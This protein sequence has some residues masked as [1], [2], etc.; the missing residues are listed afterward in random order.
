[1]N[2]IE[3][4]FC[5][6]CGFQLKIQKVLSE[7]IDANAIV[8]CE[9]YRYPII[10]GILILKK[11]STV[12]NA[13]RLMERN[14]LS[15]ALI[16]LIE[17]GPQGGDVIDHISLSLDQASHEMLG[18]TTPFH[19]LWL[20]YKKMTSRPLLEKTTKLTFFAAIDSLKWKSWGNYL[21][22]RF[23]SPDF[24]AALP[25][26]HLI[27]QTHSTILDIGCGAGHSS[28]IIAKHIPE[29]RIICADKTFINLY[30]AKK[31]FVK[32]ASFIC[33]DANNPLP[34][35]NESFSS[36]F[37][38]DAFHYVISKRLLAK[39][40]KRTL[41]PDGIL[42]LPHLHNSLTNI[43][44]GMAVEAL[45]PKRYVD[46]FDNLEVRLIPEDKV[47]E[48]F[49]ANDKIDLKEKTSEQELKNSHAIVLVASDNQR[50]FRVYQNID[51]FPKE[52]MKNLIINPIY[53]VREKRNYLH[54]TM[55]AFP[56]KLGETTDILLMKKYMPDTCVV[57]KNLIT[58]IR[59]NRITSKEFKK[60]HDLMKKFILLCIPENYM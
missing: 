6:Y 53:K 32:N 42:L 41:K 37:C 15:K 11:G 5:P 10:E 59:N 46:L 14:E 54:L 17:V 4:L 9:C 39:E 26:I 21:K 25:L 19:R 49:L 44:R 8:K 7:G 20:I 3:R 56:R 23:S 24:V 12:K 28:F 22:F 29:E 1:M 57:E 43:R 16:N 40:F 33:L 35:T 31:F 55:R 38:L 60:I 52:T 30:L 51:I 27:K 13:V 48:N 47:I 18:I 45:T 36:I 58:C 34:F 50:F 2:S